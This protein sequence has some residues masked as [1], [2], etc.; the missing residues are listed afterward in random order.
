MRPKTILRSYF[1]LAVAV[2]AFSASLVWGV[3]RLAVL[4]EDHFANESMASW[5][6]TQAEVEYLRFLDAL[7]RYGN[8]AA[9]PSR[10]ELLLRFEVFWSRLPLLVEGEE[11]KHLRAIEW[12]GDTVARAIASLE[13]VEPD[14]LALERGDRARAQATRA[15]IEGFGPLFHRLTRTALLEV[16]FDAMSVGIREDS[17][18]A[19][20]SF[21]F[22]QLSVGFLIVLL[23][24]QIRRSARYR[25]DSERARRTLT[26]ALE[27]MNEGFVVF[28]PDERLV[29][30]NRA[31]R[32]LF[33]KIAEDAV[34][35]TTF[36]ALVRRAAVA[37][38]VTDALGNETAWIEKRL[39]RFRSPAPRPTDVLLT[40]GRWVRNQERRTA[41]GGT[42]GLYT[43]I[44]EPTLAQAAVRESRQR[45][46]HAQR[47][48]S[49]GNWEWDIAT[50]KL[51]WSDEHYRIFGLDP[52]QG[53][54]TY[55]TFL[56]SVHP[57]DRKGMEYVVAR[58]LAD[59]SSTKTDFRIVRPDGIE[60]ICQGQAEAVFDESGQP[61]RVVGTVQ[62]ITE[63]KQIER[64][65]RE[66]ERFLDSIIENIPDM[67][68]VKDALTLRYVRVNKAGEE[69][70]G[71]SQDHLIGKSDHE[72]FSRDQADQ[73][74][75]FDREVVETGTILDIPEREVESYSRGTRI[76]HNRKVPI[77]DDDGAPRYV[78]CISDDITERKQT[79]RTLR[80]HQRFLD[81]I[82]ENIPDMIVVK[83][84]EGLRF[85]RVNKA[86]ERLLGRSRDDLIGKTD[87]DV[88]RP[89]QAERLIALDREVLQTGQYLETAELEV[90]LGSRG[91]RVL[92]NK[93]LP[94]LDDA[95]APKY[96]LCISE[97]IT[98]SRDAE[99]A[100]RVA[101]EEAE[102][103]NRAKSEFLSR[104]SHELR[105]P[106]NAIL[107]FGQLLEYNPAEPL[108]EVQKRHVEY[109]LSGGRHLLGLIDEILDLAKIESG[110]FELSME[111]VS[112]R[113]VI[114]ECLS[115]TRTSADEAGV[116]LVD[117]CARETAVCV[118][119][120][121]TRTKQ[122][123]LNLISNAIKYNRRG[124]TVTLRDRLNGSGRLRVEVVD[125]GVGIPPEKRG[126]LFLPFTRLSAEASGVE[127]TGIGLTIT[128]QLVERMGGRIGF[129]STVGAGSAFWFE[130]SASGAGAAPRAP[131][132]V[133]EA[134]RPPAKVQGSRT[135]LYIEDNPANLRLM[136]S[137]AKRIR[138]IT[139]LT[140]KEAERGIAL[141]R[142]H[143]P[144][145]IVMDINLPGLD[146]FEALK[147]LRKSRKTRAI[148]VVAL[149]ASAYPKDIERGLQA[150]FRHY[151]VK[152]INVNE[153]V[154]VLCEA[155]DEAA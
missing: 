12:L 94:I 27:T 121:Y 93:K 79:E 69:L 151:L 61:H 55:E 63:R 114:D 148:P 112:L 123:L 56:E 78:L 153:V 32:D 100:L 135:V 154:A 23:V 98:E 108:S 124:G 26:E 68:F 107:G 140:A 38:Q 80:E 41:D 54:P 81:S 11:S 36:E 39:R 43:D 21:A 132:A 74:A 67:I 105:T 71:H 89:D 64:A 155:L 16:R 125:T 52:E 77:L 103:A 3:H 144:A 99:R 133:I 111:D 146:G 30:C 62:D 51:W 19:L 104:M 106:M 57:D 110:R 58:T 5:V 10:D 141:A 40:D 101:K 115:L 122:V 35:G 116:E 92:H 109:I 14:L 84:A 91:V 129:K 65:L 72:L 137:I 44:T 2:V 1:G 82:I 90:E 149:S 24:R 97:D 42:V 31:Y 33:Q 75:A 70:V 83:E 13:A 138:G 88:F 131:P 50:G 96:L 25:D 60:R 17:I 34:P 8:G 134:Q 85:L 117:R 86:G 29:L 152:P 113:A 45:L 102:A 47:I 127:G 48:A 49:L 118:R 53:E 136:E 46:A 130:L 59:P 66:H 76:L 37:G 139:L 73:S 15:Q 7:D 20:A 22:I 126:E 150:G 119:A 147:R 6:A 145:V 95:G 120:D 9:E 18:L 142:E 4:Q 28:D 87:R 128:K 143:V